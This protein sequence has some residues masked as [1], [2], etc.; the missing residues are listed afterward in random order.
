MKYLKIALA[1]LLLL[2]VKSQATITVVSMTKVPDAGMEIYKAMQVTPSTTAATLDT[3]VFVPSSASAFNISNVADDSG[4]VN[5]YFNIR[6]SATDSTDRSV[7]FQVTAH[8][9]PRIGSYV[10]IEWITVQTVDDTAT[11]TVIDQF[12]SNRGVNRGDAYKA[13]LIWS[14]N[15]AKMSISPFDVV[16]YWRKAQARAA[17]AN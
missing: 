16:V 7:L 3:I 1:L 5:A 17:Y 2:A 13:R 12:K 11:T 4:Q 14:E 10:A 8:P 15:S 6:A 9:T